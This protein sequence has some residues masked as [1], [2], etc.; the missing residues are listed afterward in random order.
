[1]DIFLTNN[2]KTL[3]ELWLSL[4]RLPSIPL[5]YLCYTPSNR[6]YRKSF[7]N[8]MARGWESSSLCGS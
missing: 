2:Y 6:V 5:C 1:M 4:Y 7:W 8:N 3:M